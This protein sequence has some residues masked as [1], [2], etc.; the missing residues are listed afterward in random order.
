[1]TTHIKLVVVIPKL[2]LQ[3][4]DYIFVHL[5]S[6]GQNFWRDRWVRPENSICNSDNSWILAAKT[7][8][9]N[10]IAITHIQLEV[11]ETNWEHKHITLVEHFGKKAVSI[12]LIRSD[13]SNKESAFDDYKDLCASRVSMGRV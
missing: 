12:V 6:F 4:V 7:R 9:S 3:I 10:G 13:K 1:M 11:N 5:K 8:N 2:L